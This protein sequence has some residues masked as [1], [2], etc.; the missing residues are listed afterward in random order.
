MAGG[1]W[2][3]PM[4][5]KPWGH[6]MG[7]PNFRAWIGKAVTANGQPSVQ[8]FSYATP[9]IGPPAQQCGRVA[10]ADMHANSGDT[11]AVGLGF[12]SGGCTTSVAQLNP[13][14]KALLYALFDVQRCLGSDGD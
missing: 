8:Y 3:K 5:G 2:G 7:V 9:I 10:F 13:T 11:S 4:G 12:P 14:E 6:T 1:P